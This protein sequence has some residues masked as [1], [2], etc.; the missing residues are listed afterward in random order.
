MTESR[1]Y[2][3]TITVEDYSVCVDPYYL[4]LVR[5]R[6]DKVKWEIVPKGTNFTVHFEET[7]FSSIAFDDQNNQSGD[8]VDS[9]EGS[10]KK[11]EYSVEIPS[12]NVKKD[13]RIIIR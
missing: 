2:T 3:V 5:A 1:I 9:A 12:L 13:P 11:Y 4:E 10:G 8:I 7:P 6:R